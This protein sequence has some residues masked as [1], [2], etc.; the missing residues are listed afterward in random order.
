MTE[1][2]DKQSMTLIERLRAGVAEFPVI[3]ENPAL[4][5]NEAADRLEA[6]ERENDSLRNAVAEIAERYSYK[7]PVQYEC[8]ENRIAIKLKAMLNKGVS[9]E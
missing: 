5:M 6:V 4:I 7:H 3:I 9:D 8:A 2:T 1:S